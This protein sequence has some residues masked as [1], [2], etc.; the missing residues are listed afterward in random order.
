MPGHDGGATAPLPPRSVH[1]LVRVDAPEALLLD[2]AVKTVAA[3]AAP[4]C[5]ALLHLGDDAGLEPGRNRAVGV[6]AIVDRRKLVL[7]LHGDDSGTATRKQ[8][9]IDPALG[10]LGIANPAPVLELGGDFDREAGAGVDPGDVIVLGR[11]GAD[12]DVIRFQADVAR[13]RE[14][15]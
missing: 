10:A 2:P 8:R 3:D 14:A 6:G 7:V 5:A 15:R 13:H 4:V 9:V 12:V 11:A 1:L